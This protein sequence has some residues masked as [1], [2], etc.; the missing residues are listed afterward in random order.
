MLQPRISQGGG[1]MVRLTILV[2]TA[3]LLA[4]PLFAQTAAR[5]EGTLKDPS[6]AVVPN[7]KVTATETKTGTVR[8]TTSNTQGAFVFPSVPPGLYS[9]T[10]EASGFSKA[11]ANNIEVTVAGV[12]TQNFALKVGSTGETVTVETTATTVATTDSQISRAVTMREIDTLP[13]LGRTPITLAV[14]QP[15]IQ[16]NPGD[17]TFS[18]VNGQ[19]QGSNNSRLDGIDVNDSV[20]PRLGLSL[21]ANNTDSVAEFRMVT[22]G[23]KAEY[24][25][26]AGGQV[27]MVTR[28]GTNKFHGNAFNYHRNTVLN[29]NE[30]FAIQSGTK[31][32]KFIQNLFGGS[33]GGPI[34]KDKAFAFGN[35]QGRRTKQEIVRNR[36]VLTAAAKSGLFTY[37]P[38][39]GGAPTTFNIVANDPRGI[40]IPS[41]IAAIFAMLPNPNNTDIGDGLNTAGYRF[42]NPNDSHED[43]FTIRGDYNITSNHKAFIR[44]S[45]Q[46]NSFIDSLNGADATFPGQVHGTQGGRRWGYS[47][48]SDWSI[49]PT[50]VNEFRFGHQ[51]AL[52]AF[53]RPARLPGPMIISALYTDPLNPAFAQGRNSPVN[54]ITDNMTKV[55]GN[56]TFRF[57][58]TM[59]LTRQEGYNDAGAWPNVTLST[60]NGNTQSAVVPPNMPTSV[61]GTY[62][63]LY[64]DVLGRISQV[65]TTF[66]SLDLATFQPIGTSRVRD[67]RLND[68]G[69]Y[70]QDD[71]KV[72]RNLTM[73][74]GVRYELF[75]SPREANKIQG[76]IIGADAI[77]NYTT[78]STLTIE[79]CKGGWSKTDLNNFAPRVGFAW[80]LFGK[81][82]TAL[83]GNYGIFFDRQIGAVVSLVD[84]NTPGF[85]QTGVVRPNNP[86]D[87]RV[88][89][90]IN[91]FLPALPAAPSLTL[92]AVG[93]SSSIVVFDPNLRTGYVQNYGLN[94]QHEI[95]R[96]TVVEV[97]WVAARGVKLFMDLDYNQHKVDDGFLAD[98]LQLRAFQS[99]G[100]APSA[101]N[102]LV[103]MFGTPAAAITALGATNVSQGNVGTAANNLDIRSDVATRYAA[104][105]V[106]ANYLR[107]Y[108]Q[109]NLMVLGTNAGRNYY[110][111]LQV[112]VRRTGSTLRLNANYT[113]SKS[114]DNISVDGNGFTAPVDSYNV[115]RG[116]AIG[117]FDKTHSFNGSVIY[118]LPFG[119]GDGFKI[120]RNA[121]GWVDAI[122]GGWE[123][124]TLIVAQSGSVFSIGSTRTTHHNTTTFANYSGPRNIGD[125]VY[126]PN[127]TVTYFTAADLAN[128]GFPLPGEY[129]TSR[130]NDFRGPGFVN[131]DASLVKRIKIP[132]TENHSVTFRTEAY[133]LFNHA[134]FGLPATNITAPA[135]F[136]RISSTQG[137]RIMQLAL[138]YD[139]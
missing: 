73:N 12:I 11:V 101:G 58:G 137:G 44:W 47:I 43:Q 38:T 63:A 116:R 80:D 104:A 27:E 89:D 46:R 127:G 99:S 53:N 21:T 138:R 16:I 92:P 82:K 85:S 79:R 108:P 128:F 3:C 114:M 29:A 34:M 134:N 28:S 52:V 30:F 5:L 117:D 102:K 105:G 96:N 62:N 72:G 88:G 84:G 119:K 71:W 49:S 51:S 78:S 113:W 110:D 56:H 112:S 10:V 2:V 139:F 39:T 35:Y 98:F 14:Y 4:T 60:A 1:F 68:S 67:Y 54:V 45:W 121:P 94:L 15:G 22:A 87:N 91:N 124:G 55:W 75:K 93:R 122:I 19:R 50:L 95:V 135:T 57:G 107:Q 123:I 26:N 23:G 18:R 69:Y 20:V 97:G 37:V 131:I 66:Y 115:R 13:S 76:C 90:G 126:N 32:P 7:A 118:A 59:N 111:S 36:T 31:R 103:L 120:G 24:G 48:G 33:F 74:L 81:G 25:R 130:R 132:G 133:N 41:Q 40:G 9:I 8:E 77:A 125:V 6:G 64:N 83:R 136:G 106:P 86:G 65:S 109:F 42:L 17:N 70:F 129:G 100:T 61:A